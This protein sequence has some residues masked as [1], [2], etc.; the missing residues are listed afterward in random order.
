MTD[1]TL[2][3]AHE[4]LMVSASPS[5]PVTTLHN[6]KKKGPRGHNLVREY[7]TAL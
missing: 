2:L 1:H 6:C 4:L 5:T 7:E 3:E